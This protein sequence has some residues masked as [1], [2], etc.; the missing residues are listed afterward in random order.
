MLLELGNFR[1]STKTMATILFQG[2]ISVAITGIGVY[3]LHRLDQETASVEKAG[4]AAETSARMHRIVVELARTEYEVAAFPA[5]SVIKDA[6]R[7]LKV[8]EQAFDQGLN[9]LM[10]SADRKQMAIVKPAAQDYTTYVDDLNRVLAE[11]EKRS[12]AYRESKQDEALD[13]EIQATNEMGHEL[14][15]K[16]SD[17]SKY[18]EQEAEKV[19]HNADSSFR[20][21]SITLIALA[22]GGIICSLL[23][24][25]FVSMKGIVSPIR[26]AVGSLRG[27]AEG[28]L[29]TSVYGLGRRDEI[30]EIAET[31]Q[32]FKETAIKSR[33][34]S[35]EQARMQEE[36]Q[37]MRE[38]QERMRIERAEAQKRAEEKE[39]QD[40]ERIRREREASEKAA[41]EARRRDVLAL[42]DRFEQSVKSIVQIVN[43]SA[44]Q[45]TSTATSMSGMAEET[46]RQASVVAT[47]AKDAS[48]NAIA[49]AAAVEELTESI[50]EIRRRVDLSSHGT[51]R[52]VRETR[53]TKEIAHSM[54]EAA[55]RVGQVIQLIN[56]I[57]GQTNLLALNATIEAARAGESGRGFAVVASE[58]KSLATQTAKATDEVAAQISAMQQATT[59]V[60]N[61]IEG[62][63]QSI[64]EISEVSTGIASAVEQQDSASREISR[65]VQQSAISS[66]EVSSNIGSVTEAAADTGAAASQVLGAATELSHQSEM[67][68]SEVDKFLQGIRAA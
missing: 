63:S 40:A 62:I 9:T 41:A 5:P 10:I 68:M 28:D 30:G 50:G 19:S 44:T 52:S 58:V 55:E 38:E 35:E 65:N 1:V 37:K 59:S 26:N 11:A 49:V 64:T 39:R 13:S 33:E 25:W 15:T 61:A 51:A 42:A 7:T 36:Q 16:L 6:M 21:I 53:N 48:T 29:E 54:A 14:D 4:M 17:F 27:L 34:L 45:L 32:V 67:L 8:D 18:S 31:M 24:G 66:N 20:E 23:I 22:I 12:A 43:A 3:S 56:E 60:V 2:M 46:S 57:A 47:S